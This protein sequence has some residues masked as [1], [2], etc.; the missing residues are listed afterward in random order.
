MDPLGGS[1]SKEDL[2]DFWL[3]DIIHPGDVL[4]NAFPHKWNTQRVSIA[5]CTDDL[6]KNPSGPFASID[7]NG[8]VADK[9]GIEDA[10]YDFSEEG[11]RF[12]VELL[13]VSDIAEGD[14]I[15][16]IL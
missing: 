9:F 3:R 5:A 1:F 12:L 10:R 16:G 11:D 15:E 4:D 13:R 7:I 14:F 8:L 6:I 2:F